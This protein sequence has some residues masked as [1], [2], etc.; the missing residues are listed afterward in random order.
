ML[1]NTKEQTFLQGKMTM[2]RWVWGCLKV[3][4]MVPARLVFAGVE[5]S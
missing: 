3:W 2:A 4:F 5:K 1:Q